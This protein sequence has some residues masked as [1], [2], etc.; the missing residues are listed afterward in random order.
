MIKSFVLFST[1]LSL[2]N[3]VSLN[4]VDTN[5]D[6]DITTYSSSDYRIYL[7]NDDYARNGIYI[8]VQFMNTNKFWSDDYAEYYITAGFDVSKKNYNINYPPIDFD[9]D[10]DMKL[11]FNY[12]KNG[13][14]IG[15][16]NVSRKINN[17]EILHSKTLNQNDF[18][19]ANQFSNFNDTI[20][21]DIKLNTYLKDDNTYGYYD[22]HWAYSVTLEIKASYID[23]INN[24]IFKSYYDKTLRF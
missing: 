20:R 8:G 18:F 23:K 7:V 17:C 24:K 5:Q 15:Y 4:N 11:Y 21:E 9:V 19:Y 10:V 22:S 6:S 14:S 13:K 16:F 1:T 12:Y 2:F 3:G